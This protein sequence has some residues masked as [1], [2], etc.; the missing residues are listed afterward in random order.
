MRY[1][2]SNSQRKELLIRHQ[3]LEIAV[4]APV[5]DPPDWLAWARWSLCDDGQY[6]QS[7]DP[8]VVL[9]EYMPGGGGL[10]SI[11]GRI[12]PDGQE[13]QCLHWWV[14]IVRIRLDPPG[15]PRHRRSALQWPVSAVDARGR[16]YP[17][18]A[19]R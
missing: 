16:V 8:D 7:A 15:K 13:S 11:L 18:E 10:T 9:V 6:V 3:P 5:Q 19:A 17:P 14:E 1:N 4:P 2:L 12:L